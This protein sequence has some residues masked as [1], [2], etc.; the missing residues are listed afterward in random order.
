MAANRYT[1][2]IDQAHADKLATDELNANGQQHANDVGTCAN[3]NGP[4]WEGDENALH[5]CINGHINIQLTDINP[6]SPTHGSTTWLVTDDVCGGSGTGGCSQCIGGVNHLCEKSNTAWT[7]IASG[8]DFV[9]DSVLRVNVILKIHNS[10]NVSWNTE[11]PI[12]NLVEKC[13]A[14]VDPGLGRTYPDSNNCYFSQ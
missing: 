9:G 8:F 10:E 12:A 1:S 11:V 14:P 4:V 5:Q 13:I 6:Q 7:Q 3:N 2:I